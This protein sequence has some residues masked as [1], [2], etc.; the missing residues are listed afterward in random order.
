MSALEEA[1]L[2]K[3]S[4]KGTMGQSTMLIDKTYLARRGE[5]KGGLGPDQDRSPGGNSPGPGDRKRADG[6]LPGPLPAPLLTKGIWNFLC[7]FL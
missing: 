1:E 5:Q 7:S 6:K 4:A 2:R 3:K